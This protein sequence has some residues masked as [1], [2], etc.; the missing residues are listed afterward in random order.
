MHGPVRG[1]CQLCQ[2][3]TV[4]SP[5]Q[6]RTVDKRPPS[7]LSR[8]QTKHACAGMFLVQL[9]GSLMQASQARHSATAKCGATFMCSVPP[10]L[11]REHF[12]SSGTNLQMLYRRAVKAALEGR[13]ATARPCQRRAHMHQHAG[14]IAQR[15][16][17]RP[18][19]P[20]WPLL[21]A[22]VRFNRVWL[23]GVQRQRRAHSL[24]CA[25]KM[26]ISKFGKGPQ[27]HSISLECTWVKSPG[28]CTLRHIACPQVPQEHGMLMLISHSAPACA[29]T[30]SG[31]S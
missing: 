28:S 14:R 2:T 4:H 11:N 8:C 1:T 27:V 22:L 10:C 25:C 6:C 15:A 12:R 30:A 21:V 13:A 24:Q 5:C 19:E 29:C 26:P 18:A 3:T 17:R 16:C 23:I 20:C 31:C 9:A 7:L